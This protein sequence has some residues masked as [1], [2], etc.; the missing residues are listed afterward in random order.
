MAVRYSGLI[1]ITVVYRDQGDYK[2]TVTDTSVRHPLERGRKNSWSGFINPAPAG[3]GRGVAYD[4]PQAYDEVASAALSFARDDGDN[5]VGEKAA[6]E[7]DFSD[8]HVGRS[9][10]DAWDK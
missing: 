4:S 2:V 8:W 5:W 1:R 7:R 3:F 10:K 9:L 6:Y